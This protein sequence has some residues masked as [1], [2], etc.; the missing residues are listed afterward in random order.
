MEHVRKFHSASF[1]WQGEHRD[2]KKWRRSIPDVIPP[3]LGKR[4]RI[5]AGSP[6]PGLALFLVDLRVRKLN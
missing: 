2:K 1:E 6:K 4:I 5:Y 3:S